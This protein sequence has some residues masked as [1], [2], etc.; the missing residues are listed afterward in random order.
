MRVST[1]IKQ[2][3]VEEQSAHTEQGVFGYRITVKFRGV[4]V[5]VFHRNTMQEALNAFEAAGYQM[6]KS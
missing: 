4:I 2:F 6:A 1:A 5:D 3:D